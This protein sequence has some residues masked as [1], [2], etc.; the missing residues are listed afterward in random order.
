MKVKKIEY[1][2]DTKRKKFAVVVD[3]KDV[4]AEDDKKMFIR[5]KTGEFDAFVEE[6][7]FYKPVEAKITV[8]TR[9]VMGERYVVVEVDATEVTEVKKNTSVWTNSP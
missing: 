3:D 9:E 4:I 7:T 1:T 6:I 8:K 2:Y 5:V